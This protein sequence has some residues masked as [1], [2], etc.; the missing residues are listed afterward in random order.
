MSRTNAPRATTGTL[1]VPGAE[2]YHEVR[3]SGPLLA[4]AAAPMGADAFAPLAEMMADEHTVLTADPRGTGRSRL[5]DPSSDSTPALRSDDLARLVEHLDLGPADVL[6]SSGGAVTVLALAQALPDLVRTVIAHE[7]PLDT[8]LDDR[9]AL[10][11]GTEDMIATYLAGDVLGAWRMFM[12]QADIDLPPG[13]LEQMFGGDRDA[14]AVADERYFFE[15]ELRGTVSWT[16]DLEALRA[17]RARIVP[18]IGEDSAGEE[19]DRTTRALAAGLAME[20]TMFPGGHI[21][22]ADDPAAFAARLRE[23]LAG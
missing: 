13:V 1:R 9:E 22:F 4:L 20:P 10:L 5:D 17:S 3:G 12:D 15:H 11:A 18:A 23:V 19:C 21:A 6:G 2:L 16:P 14:Q 7:P 8:L